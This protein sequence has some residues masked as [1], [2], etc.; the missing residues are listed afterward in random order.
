MSNVL[1][2]IIKGVYQRSNKLFFNPYKKIGFSWLK[3][4]IIKNLP[5]NKLLTIKLFNNE[6][7]FYSR[8]ELLHSL[9]EIFVDEIYKQ[10]VQNSPFIIDCGANIGL[11]VIYLKQLMPN[12]EII[13]FEPDKVNFELLKKNIESFRLSNVEIRQ[14]AVWIKNTS[15]NFN[16][17][18]SLMSK[19]TYETSPNSTIVDAIRLKDVMIGEIDFL[20]IDIEGAEYKVLVDIQERLHLV[21]NIFLEYHGKFNQNHELNEM[22][23]IITKF[24]FQYYIKEATNKYPTPFMRAPSPDYDVQLNIF[25]FRS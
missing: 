1:V 4:K 11:S 19:I 5:I 9:T 7:T 20:K 15:L 3:S 24:G 25:G 10:N 12:A 23:Q 18:G 17:E 21:K 14:Q 6:L 13:A 8:E 16:S 22:L 2:N